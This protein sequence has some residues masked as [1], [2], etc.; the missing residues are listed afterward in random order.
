MGSLS[1]TLTG[2]AI[3]MGLLLLI[4]CGGNSKPAAMADFTITSTPSTV[5]LVAGAGGQQ[6][7]VNAV[8]ANGFTG[9]V[10]VAITGLP[11][12]VTANQRR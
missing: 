12:G 5:A 10:A 8:A 4:S 7:S 3:F 1:K 2:W 9:A 11:A 6:I